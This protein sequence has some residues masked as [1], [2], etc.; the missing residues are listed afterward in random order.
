[1]A[2]P[3]LRQHFTTDQTTKTIRAALGIVDELEPPDDL[4]L[5]AFNFA[6]GMLGKWYDARQV[7]PTVRGIG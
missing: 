1:M 2:E 7:V 4:R 5:A 3:I 6:L